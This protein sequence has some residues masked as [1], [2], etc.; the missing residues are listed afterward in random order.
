MSEAKDPRDVV[1]AVTRGIPHAGQ[2]TR[3]MLATSEGWEEVDANHPKVKA[4]LDQPPALVQP[5]IADVTRNATAKP[6]TEP[7]RAAPKEK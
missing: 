6:A 1:W 2:M 4:A 3:A 7:D 5:S